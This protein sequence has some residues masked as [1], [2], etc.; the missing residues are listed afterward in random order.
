MMNIA[1]STT[2]TSSVTRTVGS[3]ASWRMV[4]LRQTVV[5][6]AR[7]GR[8][9]H[10]VRTAS[11]RQTGGAISRAQH[12]AD[13]R[14]PLFED[15]IF[16]RRRPHPIIRHQLDLVQRRRAGGRCHVLQYREAVRSFH[17]QLAG[18]FAQDPV[19]EGF[20]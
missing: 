15:A 20:G 13:H 8:A 6:L 7:M 3:L 18:L 14:L 9:S 11:P 19:Y 1:I 16:V 4:F 5:L 10:T 17:I 12:L 2:T